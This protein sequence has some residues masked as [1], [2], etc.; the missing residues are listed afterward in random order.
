MTDRRIFVNAVAVLAVVS[1]LPAHAQQARKG[2]LVVWLGINPPDPGEI[3]LTID[4][5]RDG[6]RD[7]GYVDG[8]NIAVEY[9]HTNRKPERLS[10]LIE[11]Q[12][13]QK[14]DVLMSARP[15][16]L[17]AAMR[18]T[19]SVP[20]VFVTVD[21]P[22]GAGIVDSL[23]KPGRNVTGLSWDSTPKI[24][25]KQFQLLRELVPGSRELA[26][27]WNPAVKGAPAFFREAQSAATASGA[28]LGSFEVHA[29]TDFE[30]A[31]AS[32]S[33][34]GITAVL[35]LGSWFTWQYRERLTALAARHQFPAIYGNR[36]SVLAGGLM[37]Y[38]ANLPDQFRRAAG[39]V[40]KI[41][42]G[43]NPGD[44]PVEQP[45]KF[46]LVINLKVAKALGLVIPK[47]FL[48]RADELIE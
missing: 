25:G 16:V 47:T 14:V 35:V 3:E 32:M 36:D 19:R 17:L 18:A 23:A 27:L 30:S 42:K 13:Q 2:P 8:R 31:F 34:A 44:L 45:T 41:L 9:R 22:V 10:A 24:A 40:D 26:V 20:I 37:S 4:L 28:V 39:Y 11:E 7:L 6:L 48:L 12:I 1:Q 29:P 21:D 43:A 46:E 15:D 33:S 5:F 38:G